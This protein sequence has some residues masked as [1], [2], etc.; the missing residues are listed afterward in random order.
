MADRQSGQL[1]L[2]SSQ[3]SM[4]CAWK[5]W[6]QRGRNRSWSVGSNLDKQ[7]AQSAEDVVLDDERR[8]MEEKVKR[9]R[10]SAMELLWISGDTRRAERGWESA[11][12]V[13]VVVLV[14]VEEEDTWRRHRRLRWRRRRQREIQATTVMKRISAMMRTL[15][16]MDDEDDAWGGVEESEGM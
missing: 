6:Q 9:G 11:V 16:F 8:V 15:G 4:H 5:A 14:L 3:A 12:V 2:D 13:A 7:T 1:W 10:E